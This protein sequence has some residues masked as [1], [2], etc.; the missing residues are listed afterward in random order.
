MIWLSV[1][2]AIGYLLYS[3]ATRSSDRR[4]VAAAAIV[5]GESIVYLANGARCPL[6]GLAESLGAES[7]SVTDMYLPGWLA[8][9]LPAIH[10]PVLALVL[11][12][13]RG[14]LMR[15]LRACR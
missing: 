3:G 4:D 15:I 10:V 5:A 7:G 2:A 12:L 9:N 6:T 11:Y 1:E 8:H 14:I 13:H